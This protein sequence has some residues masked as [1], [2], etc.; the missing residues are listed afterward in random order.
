MYIPA[1]FREDRLDVL[2]DVIQKHSFGTIVSTGEAGLM[3]S[4]LP[5]LLDPAAGRFGT[6]AYHLA[7]A[8]PHWRDWSEGSEVMVMFRGPHAYVSP[9]WY[10]SRE[11][12]PT[13]NYIAVHA[14]G[15]PR[16][17]EGG[18]DLLQLLQRLTARSEGDSREAWQVP[19]PDDYVEKMMGAIVGFRLEITRLE[20][21]FKLSQN[22]SAEDAAAVIGTFERS[23]S[24]DERALADL[25]AEAL[26]APA[27]ERRR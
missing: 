22:R 12:V 25:M 14:Y 17:I 5:F 20:G 16:M 2:H 23:T 18:G 15:I 26:G 3:A 19:W 9:T 7:R 4:H 13:W 10:V 11:A 8:N 24:A 27:A 21:K 6:L 1:S